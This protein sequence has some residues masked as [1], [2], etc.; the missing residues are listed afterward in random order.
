MS[1]L[2]I[3]DGMP[4]HH[5]LLALPRK[6]RYTWIEL[7]C[8]VARQGN[9]GHVPSGV[10]DLL[11]YVT[12]GFLKS[13]VQVGLL[14]DTDEGLQVHDWHI[15]N[16]KVETESELDDR[17]REAFTKMPGASAN[18]VV[19]LVGGRRKDVLEAVKRYRM[20]PNE[21]PPG[22]DDQFPELAGTGSRAGTH[23]RTPSPTPL[24]PPTA[25]T[26]SSV[27]D[28]AAATERLVAAGWTQGQIHRAADDLGRAIAWLDH[29]A[30][31]PTCHSPGA[32]AWEQ[33]SGSTAWPTP[34]RSSV[35]PGAQGTRSI[36]APQPEREPEPVI[37][38]AP[39]PPDFL[40][41]A[42]RRPEP[43]DDDDQADAA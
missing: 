38:P 15:Y 12:P 28:A 16:P 6:D 18:D 34:P 35:I 2:R 13:C 19:Q 5:K 25:A 29:A 10:V 40:A 20:V 36:A 32:L 14:D 17:V 42:G 22:T 21:V 31:D 4:E 37:V 39:P 41:L 27:D 11:R 1:W 3:D 26:T 30:A 43:P 9:G 23:A 8:Y 33:W 7:L 24:E